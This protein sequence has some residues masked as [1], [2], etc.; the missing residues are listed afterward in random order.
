MPLVRVRQ[1]LLPGKGVKLVADHVEHRVEPAVFQRRL[2]PPVDK[3]RRDRKFDL[4]RAARLNQP[5]QRG[6][7]QQ[8]QGLI[9]SAEVRGANRLALVHGDATYQLRA[10]FGKEQLR[11]KRVDRSELTSFIQQARPAGDFTHHLGISG[12]PSKTVHHVLFG[13]DGRA[14]S[15]IA[16]VRSNPGLQGCDKCLCGLCR[17]R[18]QIREVRK[19]RQCGVG[20][21]GGSKFCHRL[22]SLC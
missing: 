5:P 14:V 21:I 15:P 16:D 8:R 2:A 13:I 22:V 19:D 10:I 17:F 6:G 9:G 1:H 11:E 20:R 7:L 4:L 12:V 3:Y 18:K